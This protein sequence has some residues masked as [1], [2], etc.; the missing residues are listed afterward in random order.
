MMIFANVPESKRKL[1]Y[2]L[3]VLRPRGSTSPTLEME[4]PIDLLRV[5]SETTHSLDSSSQVG[6]HNCPSRCKADLT[7]QAMWEGLG[8]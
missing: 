2:L 7:L 5:A 3:F 4:S 1:R 8:V 6:L